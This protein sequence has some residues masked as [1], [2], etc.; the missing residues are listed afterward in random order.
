MDIFLDSSD[1]VQIQ[2]FVDLGIIDGI[3]TNPSI[4]AKEKLSFENL[5]NQIC[6]IFNGPVSVEVIANNST[7]IIKEAIQLSKINN[8]IVIKIPATFEGFKCLKNLSERGIKTNFTI[9]YTL[10]Q[11][12]L[13]AKLGATYVSAFVGRLDATSTG[14]IKLIKEITRV[15]KNY[16]FQTKVIAASMRN[17][18]YV[19]KAALAGAHIA[20]IPPNVLDNMMESELTQVTLKG[21]LDEWSS[22]KK[23]EEYKKY[24]HNGT[25][26]EAK[27]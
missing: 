10:N 6:N 13:A 5:I 11:A 14:G 3:T 27:K 12:L 22:T 20:T 26:N 18:I 23:N 7:S 21:F 24:L 25:I 8:N 1:L 4:L 15:Y 16:N 17:E 19:K 2:K 9:L